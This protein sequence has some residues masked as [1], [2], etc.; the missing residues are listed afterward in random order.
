MQFLPFQRVIITSKGKDG[1]VCVR[2]V[3]DRPLHKHRVF[4][5]VAEGHSIQIAAVNDCFIIEK[6]DLFGVAGKEEG[7]KSSMLHR[8]KTRSYTVWRHNPA[9]T[10]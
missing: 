3:Q 8:S 2:S 6:K 10:A 9:C 1:A 7:V 4:L 5:P